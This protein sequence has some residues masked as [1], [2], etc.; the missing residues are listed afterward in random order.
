MNE[1]M[2]NDLKLQLELAEMSIKK[3]D[4]VAKKSMAELQEWD[5]KGE[6]R[7]LQLKST[8][9][10][11]KEKME[12]ERENLAKMKRQLID[13]QAGRIEQTEIIETP[14][15]TR[16]DEI[17][18]VLQNFMENGKGWLDVAPELRHIVAEWFNVHIERLKVRP[19]GGKPCMTD[20]W[21][22]IVYNQLLYWKD[23]RHVEPSE[24]LEKYGKEEKK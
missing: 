3:N 18:H 13:L 7:R 1:K 20:Y 8:I 22:Q 9:A 12:E 6:E 24:I 15:A 23:L 11:S 21:T 4:Q 5:R 10:V 2:I 16:S 17:P 14:R 19:R